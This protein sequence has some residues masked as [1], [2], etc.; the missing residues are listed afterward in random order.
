MRGARA[1]GWNGQAG[2]SSRVC[3][4]QGAHAGVGVALDGGLDEGGQQ[5]LVAVEVGGAEGVGEAEPGERLEVAGGE[6]GP[7]GA[8]DDAAE[9]A[10]AGADAGDDEA[11]HEVGAVGGDRQGDAAAEGEAAQ[12]DG[13]GQIEGE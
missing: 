10:P 2:L 12:V 5:G 4:E 8:D 1:V 11:A 3:V 9:R 13:A 7:P 6:G